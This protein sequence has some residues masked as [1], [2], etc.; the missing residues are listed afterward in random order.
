[1]HA[2]LLKIAS[3]KGERISI[4]SRPKVGPNA[5]RD[6]AAENR[7]RKTLGESA[8]IR[9]AKRGE[10]ALNLFGPRSRERLALTIVLG[11]AQYLNAEFA[12][13][14]GAS[15]LPELIFA[16]LV[17]ALALLAVALWL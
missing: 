13:P 12:W 1:E 14:P 16:S 17:A 5:E 9:I 2:K 15:L 11:P 10:P 4:G 3:I 6:T 7:L 8:D